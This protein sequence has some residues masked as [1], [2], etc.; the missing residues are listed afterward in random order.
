MVQVFAFDVYAGSAEILTEILEI[1]E[2]CW[3][4]GVARHE[5]HILVPKG[6]IS[7]R[8]GEGSAELVDGL[9]QNF[10]NKC[11]TEGA[12]IPLTSRCELKEFLVHAGRGPSLVGDVCDSE[13]LSAKGLWLPMCRAWSGSFCSR[14]ICPGGGAATEAAKLASV[15]SGRCSGQH[16]MHENP[17]S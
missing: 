10:W 16:S 11:P 5:G 7:L 8:R 15:S 4:T 14:G 6:W 9:V 1:G 12:V 2:R 13:R 17:A 3:T